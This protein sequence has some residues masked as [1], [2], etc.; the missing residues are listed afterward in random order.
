LPELAYFLGLPATDRFGLGG[1]LLRRQFLLESKSPD[2]GTVSFEPEPAQQFR[3][4]RAVTAAVFKE[5]TRFGLG[6]AWPWLTPIATRGSRTPAFGSA[7]P[8]GSEIGGIKFIK[9]ARADAQF[10]RALRRFYFA[11]TKSDHNIT[12]ERGAKSL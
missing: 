6:L 5:L 3:S 1:W 10:C 8:N 2:R 9:S 7:L 4:D 12:D 11:S